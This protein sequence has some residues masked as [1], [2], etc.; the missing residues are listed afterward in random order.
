MTIEQLL[1]RL[2]EEIS[3]VRIKETVAAIARHHRTQASPGYDAAVEDVRGALRDAGI[4]S[5]VHDY[6]AD[7]VSKTYEWTCPPAWTIR[8]GRLLQTAPKKTELIR[9]EDVPT[10]VMAHSPGGVAEGRLVHVGKGVD[11]GDYDGID[12][13]DA[14]VLAHG[15]GPLVVREAA[16][17][18]A[19][20]VVIYPD[21]DRAAASHDLVQYAGIFPTADA[22]PTL[23]PSFSVSRRI[24][25]RLIRSLAKGEVRLRGEVDATFIDHPLRALEASIPG[26]DPAAHEILLT[27]H[28]CHPRQSA[29]DNASGSAVLV[30]LARTFARL[31]NELPLRNTI[32]F[33]WI[34]EF[35]GSLPWSVEHADTLAKTLFT[36]NLDMVGQSPELIG[37][38][39]LAFRIP[40]NLPTFLNAMIEPVTHAVADCSG[41]L[42]PQGSQRRLH[43]VFDLPSGGSDHLVFAAAP[44]SI[45]SLMLG[46]DDP[47]W[48]TDLDTLE[49]VDPTRLKQVA[50]I[51][52]LLAGLPSVAETEARRIAEWTLA[53]G[54]R[55]LTEASQIAQGAEA[56]DPG[57]LLD[58]ALRVE[59]KRVRSLAAILPRSDAL[60]GQIALL[61]SVR[62]HLAP[63]ASS[64]SEAGDRPR[65]QID[66]PLVY[67][68]TEQLNEEEAEFFSERLSANHRAMIESLLALCDGEHTPEEIALQ[69]SLDVRRAVPVEDVSRGI[70]ILRKVGYVAA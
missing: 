57:Q 43:W 56:T 62:S 51:T 69:L 18:G 46:H 5:V 6:P 36:V 55:A 53:Y 3:G 17:R 1:A 44:H 39:L 10:C 14:F 11:P 31:R 67:A 28:L 23:V 8:T 65:R 20:G 9:F 59:R 61:E 66:G 64:P 30:E 29:N 12:V 45:P 37:N 42:S 33:L 41:T 49:K 63:P 40:N 25:D 38:P 60:D 16:K 13:Q 70:A 26:T 15:R 50:A 7:G 68:F 19:I 32:R 21:G 47:Y 34:P 4:D 22:I 52:G 58:I 24:A 54:V 27:A 35:Y 2:A 48:H